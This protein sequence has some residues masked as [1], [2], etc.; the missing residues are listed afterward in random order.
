MSQLEAQRKY[1]TN[2]NNW[3]ESHKTSMTTFTSRA[4]SHVYK[5]QN[6]KYVGFGFNSKHLLINP[7]P[8]VGPFNSHI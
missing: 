8:T 4:F 6:K 2:N 7:A 1:T 3:H 5:S